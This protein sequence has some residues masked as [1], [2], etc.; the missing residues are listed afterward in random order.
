MAVPKNKRYKQVVKTRRSL[1]KLNLITKKNLTLSKFKNYVNPSSNYKSTVLCA[2][3]KNYEIVKKICA[4]CYV[5]AF[6][7]FFKTR[8][9]SQF[10]RQ[11]FM[12]VNRHYAKL[13]KT[14]IPPR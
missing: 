9:R 4:H 12:L 5:T 6:A 2:F 14:L 11:Q 13:S 3:C 7:L 1:Q 10:T 8:K